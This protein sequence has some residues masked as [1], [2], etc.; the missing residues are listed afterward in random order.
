MK[1]AF[2]VNFLHVFVTTWGFS[3]S[4]V[5]T[6]VISVNWFLARWRAQ[7]YL[8]KSYMIPKVSINIWAWKMRLNHIK[9]LR[10]AAPPSTGRRGASA[11]LSYSGGRKA[12]WREGTQRVLCES[13]IIDTW[14]TKMNV[15]CKEYSKCLRCLHVLLYFCSLRDA[16]P[17]SIYAS[18]IQVLF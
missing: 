18:L 4:N 11:Q 14:Y 2:W 9:A 15:F 6:L 16:Y 12:L 3:L 7:K 1:N 5:E 10:T 17:I 8:S 13:S